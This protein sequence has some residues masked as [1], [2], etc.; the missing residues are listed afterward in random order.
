MFKTHFFNEKMLRTH[1]SPLLQ[2]CLEISARRLKI[3]SSVS[4]IERK[5]VV[6]E[7]S[8]NAPLNT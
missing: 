5:N 1:R 6:L 2:P 3:F 8:Q 7:I 4:E